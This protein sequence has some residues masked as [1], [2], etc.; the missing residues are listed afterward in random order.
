MFES[1]QDPLKKPK[2]DPACKNR[3]RQYQG[4]LRGR[5][6]D[7]SEPQETPEILS[8]LLFEGGSLGQV[9]CNLRTIPVFPKGGENGELE[10]RKSLRTQVANSSPN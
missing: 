7:S 1:H 4:R 3:E 2:R 8:F 6:N 9:E 10:I 5:G